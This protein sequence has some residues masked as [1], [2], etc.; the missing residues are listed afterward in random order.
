MKRQLENEQYEKNVNQM[1]HL[2]VKNK[3]NTV[4]KR[5]F[6]KML[7]PYSSHQDH[8]ILALTTSAMTWKLYI[9]CL[10][11]MFSKTDLIYSEMKYLW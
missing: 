2:T 11:E 7:F 8:V 6:F 4:Y 5:E 3:K 9:S 10:R 1:L